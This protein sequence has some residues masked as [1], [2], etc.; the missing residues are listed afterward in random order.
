MQMKFPFIFYI[1]YFDGIPEV[2]TL[3]LVEV[4]SGPA[5]PAAVGD[6]AAVR[7]V[8]VRVR[9]LP[10]PEAAWAAGCPPVGGDHGHPGPD[11]R[12]HL[13]SPGPALTPRRQCGHWRLSGHLVT[14]PSISG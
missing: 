13:T 5:G 1:Y 11:V 10:G 14:L 8:N 6:E 9:Q 3:V 12:E 4:I 2:S 7:T